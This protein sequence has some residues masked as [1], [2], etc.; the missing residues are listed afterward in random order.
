MSAFAAIVFDKAHFLNPGIF[1]KTKKDFL[2]ASAVCHW[3][4][5]VMSLCFLDYCRDTRYRTNCEA[6]E[7]KM[8]PHLRSTLHACF[9]NV[10]KRAF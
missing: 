2:H 8:D 9:S 10:G 5:V 3:F 4:H 1:S 7:H 6:V